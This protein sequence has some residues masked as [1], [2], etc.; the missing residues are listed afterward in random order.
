MLGAQGGDQQFLTSFL[1]ND[2]VAIDAGA[3]GFFRKAEEQA[4]VKHVFLSHSHIDHTASLP[5]FLENVFEGG[6]EG[7]N[8]YGSQSVLDCLQT[9]MFNDRIW[10]DFIRFSRQG[11]PF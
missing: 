4:R 8:V 3:L 11:P 10:P 2:T 9:D 5:V 6:T 1:V 7:V